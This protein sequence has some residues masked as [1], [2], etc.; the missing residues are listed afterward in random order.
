MRP[1]ARRGRLG[2]TALKKLRGHLQP[3]PEGLQAQP[4]AAGDPFDLGELLRATLKTE[5]WR[6]WRLLPH[7]GQVMAWF[8]ESTMRS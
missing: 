2:M 3:Q 6:V 7:F 4:G 1:S 8:R 5:S